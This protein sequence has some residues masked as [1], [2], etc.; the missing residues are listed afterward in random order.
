[1]HMSPKSQSGYV[2]LRS[3]DPQDTPEINFRFFA[4]GGDEDLQEMLDAIKVVQS[5]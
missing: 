5:A 4:H 3:A 2:R 1:M